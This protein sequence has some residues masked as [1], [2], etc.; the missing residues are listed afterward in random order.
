MKN[1]I[2]KAML[3]ACIGGGALA[4]SLAASPAFAETGNDPGTGLPS[5]RT[6]ATEHM[7]GTVTAIDKS[8]RTVTVKTDAGEKRTFDVPSDVKAFD[9]LKTGDKI[10]ADYTESIAIAVLP[11]GSKMSDSEKAS[12]MKTGKG[13]GAAGR[14]VTVSAHVVSVDPAANTIT[15]KTPKGVI[16]TVNVQDPDN[17]A[18][19]PSIKPGQVMQFTYTEAMAVSITPAAK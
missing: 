17:Q 14:Q 2:K 1:Q 19:L 7:S 12:A 5:S 15:L 3:V 10:D 6:A 8:T 9:K 11:A 13:S 16:E 18:K 4:I